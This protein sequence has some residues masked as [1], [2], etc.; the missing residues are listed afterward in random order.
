M[1]PVCLPSWLLDH[2]AAGPVPVYGDLG[3]AEDDRRSLASLRVTDAY[4]AILWQSDAKPHE[5]EQALAW[6]RERAAGREVI[7]EGKP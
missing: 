3:T 4:I 2:V 7:V 5:R 6:V 1:T